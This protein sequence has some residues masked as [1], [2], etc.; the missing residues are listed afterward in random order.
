[1]HHRSGSI[2]QTLLAARAAREEL[3]AHGNAVLKALV[4][5]AEGTTYLR[6]GD[7]D[8]ACAVLADAVRTAAAGDREDLR[9]RCLATL[10]LAEACRGHLSRAQALA[11]T[12]ERLAAES[13]AAAERPAATHLAHLWVALERQDLARAQHS[14]DRARRLPETQDDSLLS[15]VSWLLRVRLLRD[16]GDRVGARCALR[17]PEPPDSWLRGSI[18]AEAAGVGLDLAGPNDVIRHRT[19]TASQRVQEL[20]DHAQAEWLAGN[21]RGGRSWVAKALL[22]ARGERIR[23]PFRHTPER[24]QAVIRNDAG[25][26][27]LAGWLR[28]GQ[29]TDPDPADDP[30]A[31][32]EELSE[33]ELDV[34][35]LLATLRT[36]YEISAELFISVNTVKTHVRNILRKLSV[37]SRND[38]VRR[39]WDLDLI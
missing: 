10:A 35:R 2:D 5:S 32:F 36:T 1:M 9:L 37:S 6:G 38:A 13:V 22:L 26:R 27:S 17:N 24:L 8:L 12:A 3:A 23:R 16:R 19:T 15:A 31:V 18:A 11:D 14:L 34:L 29:T 28:P 4:V 25:L 39:A 21:V 33:R 7:L 20:L 30:A